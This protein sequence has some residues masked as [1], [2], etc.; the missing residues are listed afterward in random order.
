MTT[1][2]TGNPLGSVSPKDLFDNS[3]N[4]DRAVNGAALIWKD[5]FDR[6]RLSWAGIED[7]ARIDI[8][9]AAEQA[10]EEATI[11]AA[12]LRDQAQ[13]ARDDARSARD[14]AIAAAAASGE[15]VFAETYADALGKLPLPEGA[16]VEVGRDETLDESRTR[17]VV[18]GNQLRF[19]VN[20]DLVR[21]ALAQPDGAEIVGFRRPETTA[22]RRNL[23]DR[24]NDTI[25]VRDYINTPVD[26]VTSNQEGIVAAVAAANNMGATLY[27]P[28]GMYVSDANIPD[29][30][31]VT[32]RGDGKIIRGLVVFHVDIKEGQENELHCAP[33]A[34]PGN[35]GLTPSE[36][37]LLDQTTLALKNYGPHLRGRWTARLAA[38]TYPGLAR[39]SRITGMSSSRFV[40]FL[41]PD[42]GGHPNKPT[43][44][45]DGGS[46]SLGLFSAK[47]MGF[48]LW[49]GDIKFQFTG[50]EATGVSDGAICQWDN[51]HQENC[52]YGLSG[53]AH[54]QIYLSGGIHEFTGTFNGYS[55][56]RSIFNTKHN[57]GYRYDESL[58]YG[59]GD[60]EYNGAQLIGNGKG[61]GMH[62]QEGATGH[63][64]SLLI[65][66]FTNGVSLAGL[67]RMHL[68]YVEFRNN[69]TAANVENASNIY[70]NNVIWNGRGPNKNGVLIDYRGGI[71][72]NTMM[73]P[74]VQLVGFSDA[75]S[76]N[77]TSTT[78]VG[79]ATPYVL[80]GTD[81]RRGFMVKVVA[82]GRLTGTRGTKSLNLAVGG[83]FIC[84]IVFP[85]TVEGTFYAELGFIKTTGDYLL[86]FGFGTAGG[87]SAQLGAGES[88]AQYQQVAIA[89]DDGISR[90]VELQ[91]NVSV[92]GDSIQFGA[93]QCHRAG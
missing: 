17:Y 54:S 59:I 34:L 55:L 42:V 67:S 21:I 65:D 32:H 80:D 91:A 41:G 84:S 57:I 33:D 60:P 2:K 85:A 69:S 12:E 9:A 78:R 30:H 93:V 11:Q 39:T 4:L 61:R 16:V 31:R 44:I 52:Y 86:P 27:W 81:N 62:A 74:Q 40:R 1:Y 22:V 46:S 66:R 38:G 63:V 89:L 90:G 82:H 47:G 73:A 25:S 15:F 70:D 56:I 68:E 45:I 48:Q 7:R 20:L 64:R 53:G 75:Q 14:D 35:D 36:P 13:V 51:V 49:L 72:T 3:E 10:A 87:S 58:G 6:D 23:L 50:G 76:V 43:A 19:A 88:A 26:G 24:G 29:F 92:S 5:R 28:S 37:M 71:K 79:V 8:V 77:I 83:G 18:E